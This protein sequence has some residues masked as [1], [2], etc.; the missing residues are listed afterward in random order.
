MELAYITY[1]SSSDLSNAKKLVLTEHHLPETGTVSAGA[2]LIAAVITRYKRQL[3]EED[4][5]EMNLALTKLVTQR[6]PN[7][8]KLLKH[9]LHS[10]KTGL[11]HSKQVLERH[12]GKVKLSSVTELENPEA[13]L[14]ACIQFATILEMRTRRNLS[15]LISEALGTITPEQFFD[16]YELA[17]SKIYLP[18]EAERAKK[19]LK[20]TTDKPTEQEIKKSWRG[21]AKK[22][23]PDINK[24]PE[25]DIDTINEAKEAL[26]RWLQNQDM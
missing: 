6:N 13:H 19:V 20:I 18:L 26:L 21:A 5:K 14:F 1:H 3:N 2:M 12:N 4:D 17:S 25:Y 9:Q 11:V 22:A 15:A 10:D 23:H 7:I 24:N 8:G 16:K